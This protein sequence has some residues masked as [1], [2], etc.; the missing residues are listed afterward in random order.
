[1]VKIVKK[2]DIHTVINRTRTPNSKLDRC[3]IRV[4]Q[5]IKR[6]S[7]EEEESQLFTKARR[8]AVEFM[9]IFNRISKKQPHQPHSLPSLV[10]PH[11]IPRTSC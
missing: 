5:E 4:F 9:S 11:S 10:L 8:L 7:G 1:M 3:V 2:L 6:L